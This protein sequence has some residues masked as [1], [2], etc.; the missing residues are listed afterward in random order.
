MVKSLYRIRLLAVIEPFIGSENVRRFFDVLESTDSAIGGSTLP[1]V[2]AP[3]TS[4]G[5]AWMPSNLNIYV[6][7]GRGQ[8]WKD[9]FTD[10]HL[11]E[12]ASQPG[13][14]SRYNLVTNSH[15]QYQS[16]LPSR[17]ILL[18]ES[19][20]GGNNPM[21]LFVNNLPNYMNNE[22]LAVEFLKYDIAILSASIRPAWNIIRNCLLSHLSIFYVEHAHQVD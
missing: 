21:R 18:S 12:S 9:F 7:F 20:D 22:A 16:R 1:R 10:I 5:E 15:V 19:I 6:S 17:P 11:L 2:L 13:V 3:P 14:A 4:P 8:L